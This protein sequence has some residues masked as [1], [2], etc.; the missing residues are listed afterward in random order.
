ML[1]G[2]EKHAYM[3][4]T[5]LL[6]KSRLL[7]LVTTVRGCGFPQECSEGTT[8]TARILGLLR[9]HLRLCCYFKAAFP[10]WNQIDK[11]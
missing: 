11:K 10:L 9:I 3:L 6:M 5:V 7:I 2:R 1:F 4:D 8:F